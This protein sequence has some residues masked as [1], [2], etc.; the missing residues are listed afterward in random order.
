MD[1]IVA[2]VSWHDEE[3]TIPADYVVRRS[4]GEFEALLAN[5]ENDVSAGVFVSIDLACRAIRL[6]RDN[7]QLR[8][9]RGLNQVWFQWTQQHNLAWRWWQQHFSK[10]F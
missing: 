1:D 4:N 10:P 6:T 3:G 8:L 9:V 2:V 7:E 5:R